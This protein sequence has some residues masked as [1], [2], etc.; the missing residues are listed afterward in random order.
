MK[1]GFICNEQNIVFTYSE[2]NIGFVIN[3][4]ILNSFLM[5]QTSASFEV[6]ITLDSFINERSIGLI[7]NDETLDWLQ[8]TKFGF[9]F[10]KPNIG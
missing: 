8:M 1:H 7:R 6:K 9:I 3:D 5:N 4:K 10:N 2:R